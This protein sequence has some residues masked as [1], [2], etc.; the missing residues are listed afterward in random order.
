MHKEATE[1][2]SIERLRKT[3]GKTFE[4]SEQDIPETAPQTT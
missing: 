2:E 4:R 1:I 3:R